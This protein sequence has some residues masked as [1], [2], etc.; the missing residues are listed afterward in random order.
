MFLQR[1]TKIKA[2]GRVLGY[3]EVSILESIL[4]AAFSCPCIHMLLVVFSV[5]VT[6]IGG[7]VPTEFPTDLFFKVSG[8]ND[9]NNCRAF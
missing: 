3:K 9:I 4:S 1:T 7:G 5:D 8:N 6:R 2:N